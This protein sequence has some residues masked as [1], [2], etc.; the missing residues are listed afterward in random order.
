M[1]LQIQPGNTEAAI[2]ARLIQ[3][4]T[5]MD[6]HVAQHFLSLDFEPEDVDRMNLLAERS[7]EGGLSAHE[8]AEAQKPIIWLSVA[9]TVTATR[10]PISQAVTPK[11]AMSCDSFTLAGMSGAN[12]LSSTAQSSAE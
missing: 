12:T 4:R 8:E 1:G 6:S 2:L 3:S 9:F 10:V 5:E 7:R 11:P